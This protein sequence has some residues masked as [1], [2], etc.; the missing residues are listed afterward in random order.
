MLSRNEISAISHKSFHPCY[1]YPLPCSTPMIQ[2]RVLERLRGADSIPRPPHLPQR[3]LHHYHLKKAV[4]ILKNYPSLQ[5]GGIFVEMS[6]RGGGENWKSKGKFLAK[7]FRFVFGKKG[8]RV[9][10]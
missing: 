8:V 10:F 7:H 9:I 5:G 2:L 4:N 1:H 6:G 3:M